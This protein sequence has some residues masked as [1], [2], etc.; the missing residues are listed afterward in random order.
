MTRAAAAG[1][2]VEKSAR[3]AQ[4]LIPTGPAHVIGATVQYWLTDEAVKRGLAIVIVLVTPET[5]LI[6]GG[7]ALVLGMETDA[8][9]AMSAAGNVADTGI[10]EEA[11]TMIA[12]ATATDICDALARLMAAASDSVRKLKIK[13][14]QKATGCRHSRWN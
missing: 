4:G 2:V 7:L 9:L 6:V 5:L 14:T 11:R 3:Y 10:M 1:F 12:A 13:A 8:P